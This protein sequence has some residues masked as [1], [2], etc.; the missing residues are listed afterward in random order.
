MVFSYLL[1][2]IFSLEQCSKPLLVDVYRG[3]YYPLYIGGYQNGIH[4]LG[5]LA[6]FPIRIPL[7]PISPYNHHITTMQ[8]PYNQ[9]TTTIYIYKI[10]I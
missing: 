4:E 5:I 10:T 8:P 2:Q 7:D 6:G 3:L 9:H 1:V